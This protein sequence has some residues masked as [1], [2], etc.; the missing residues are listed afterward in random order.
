[1]PL[2]LSPSPSLTRLPGRWED[3]TLP[4]R[5]DDPAVSAVLEFQSPTGALVAAP[6]P[7][8]V[9]RTIRAIGLLFASALLAMW[10]IPID[11]VVTAGGKV[12]AQAPLMVVQPLET[13]IIRSID[14]TE[15]QKVHAGDL[16][17][18]LD[19]TFA[20]ADVSAVQGQ[21]SNL[22]AE[23]A[24]MRAELEERSFEYSGLDPSMLLQAAI[25]A[26][27]TSERKFKLEFYRQKIDS[28]GATVARSVADAGALRERL[29]VAQAVESMRKKLEA[30]QAGSRL[31]SLIAIDNR[32]EVERS[33]STAV[34][35]GESARAELAAMTAERDGYI[36]N[37]RGQLAQTLSDQ[38]RK[39]S[40]AREALNKAL[41]RR[42]LIELRADRNATVLTIAK[43]SEGS[44]LQPGE[45]L[46]TL[47]PSDALLEVEVNIAGRDDGFVNVG[48]AVAIKFDTFP[49]TQYGLA[50]GTVRTISADSFTAQDNKPRSGSV[51]WNPGSTEPFY[52]SRI[53]IEYAKLHNLPSGFHL[54]PGMPVTADIK[55]GRRTVLGYLLGRVL[56]VVSEGMREP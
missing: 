5:W 14:V 26:Q 2:F 1:M 23:V 27:R 10:L 30:L 54:V 24:R 43:V 35:S 19:P 8:T 3:P 18:R 56:P 40:D 48:A 16:L 29:G 12:V 42:Q 49:F 9:R 50:Y 28:L 32:L 52:R 44:V 39:L 11:R 21:V 34:N 47:V 20:S 6:V 7:V 22:Q 37:W 45:Q 51:P 13:S 55:V 15:G 17:A 36:Q 33:L 4:S 46:I 53:K 41:L 31:N 25:Y 38:S